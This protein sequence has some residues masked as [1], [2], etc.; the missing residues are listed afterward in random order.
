MMR[1][2]VPALIPVTCAWFSGITRHTTRS[3]YGRPPSPSGKSGFASKT[4]RS[5][6]RCDTKRKGPLP[7]GARLNAACR[8]RSGGIESSRWR[9]MIGKT[10][11][12]AR[13][14]ACGS[15]RK[16][17]EKLSITSAAPQPAKK[18][19]FGKPVPGSVARA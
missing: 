10:G 12:P 15:N 5:F 2:T 4:Q 11:S 7:T 14:S 6:G 9:G 8:S 17:T 18:P 19:V 1:S 13:G 16:R 3:R